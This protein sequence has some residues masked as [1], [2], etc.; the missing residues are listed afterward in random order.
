MVFVKDGL[1]PFIVPT[2]TCTTSEN[3]L[4]KISLK[5]FQSL[6][7]DIHHTS[8]NLAIIG[9]FNFYLETICSNSKTFH[10]LIDS[11]DLIQKVNFTTHIHGH[12]LDSIPLMLFQPFFS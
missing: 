4:I 6:L 9:G 2:K 5:Q 3:F 10:S 11:F 7:E 1:E 8:E 12:T